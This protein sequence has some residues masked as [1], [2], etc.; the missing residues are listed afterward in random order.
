MARMRA[1]GL[2]HRAS[3]LAYGA[4]SRVA[5]VRPVAIP[6]ARV[7]G[8]G[9]VVRR[10]TD[11][12]VESFPRC[13]SSFAVHALRLAQ[14]P[15]A[16]RIAHHTHMPAQVLE[17]ARLGIPTIVLI[18]APVEAVLSHVIHTPALT[19]E[20][21]LRGFVRFYEPLRGTREAFVVGTFAEVTQDFGVVID[22]LNDR[23]GTEFVRFVPTRAN[24]DRLVQEVETDFRSRVPS[25]EERERIIPRPSSLRESMK[26]QVREEYAL[27]SAELRRRADAVYE[28]FVQR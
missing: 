5:A 21:S 23:F 19:I 26:A 14:E 28:D 25:V 13:A 22:R 6:L 3:R 15:R 24:L 4:K 1:V 27:S 12:V 2:R 7:R 16:L 10:D 18:R 8:R 17:A 9:E 11:V 20:D